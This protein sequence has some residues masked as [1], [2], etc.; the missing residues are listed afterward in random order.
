MSENTLEFDPAEAQIVARAGNPTVT[1]RRIWYSV[2]FPLVLIAL[3]VVMFRRD[4]QPRFLLWLFVGYVTISM[5]EKVAYGIAVLSYKSVIRKL[6]KRVSE[7][8]G[9]AAAG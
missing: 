1:R 7:L 6:L 5:L 8:E 3:A 9:R 4:A 2:L